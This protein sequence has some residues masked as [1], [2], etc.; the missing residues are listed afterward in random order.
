M[1]GESS[2]AV[3]VPAHKTS[4][5]PVEALP[6]AA[7]DRGAGHMPVSR[8]CL[9]RTRGHGRLVGQGRTTEAFQFRVIEPSHAHAGSV[10]LLSPDFFD[11]ELRV[12]LRQ[13]PAIQ[14]DHPKRETGCLRH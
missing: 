3:Q 8:G 9:G 11:A 2:A 4:N 13:H 10:G 6:P 14:W 1:N 7:K 5:G 12:R